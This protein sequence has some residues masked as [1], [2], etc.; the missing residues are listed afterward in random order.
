MRNIQWLEIIDSVERIT[1]V[2]ILAP[3]FPKVGK[4]KH[5]VKRKEVRIKKK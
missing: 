5:L 1:Y 4:N 2:F 3:P